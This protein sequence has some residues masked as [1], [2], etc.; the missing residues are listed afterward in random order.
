MQTLH[1][2]H[3]DL[4][5]DFDQSLVDFDFDFEFDQSTVELR[6]AGGGR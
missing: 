5:L 1:N 4:D 2:S 3:V 6:L